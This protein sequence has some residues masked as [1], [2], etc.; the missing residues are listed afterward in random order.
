MPEQALPRR[1]ILAA[2]AI[3]IVA[4]GLRLWN[5]G[6]GIPYNVGQDEPHIMERVVRMMKTGDFNPHF[7]DW[8]SLTFYLNLVVSVVAFLFGAM[9]GAWSHLDQISADQLY[10]AGRQFTA[11]LGAATVAL[12][13]AAARRWSTAVG[14]FAAGFMAVMPNHVRESHYV[15]TDVPTTFFVTLSLLLALRAV[16]RA[17][18]RSIG[19]AGFAVGLAASCKYNGSIAIVLPLIAIAHLG[20]G[21]RVTGP[22]IGLVAVT[23]L[24]GFLVGTPY[25]ILDLPAFLNDYARLAMVFAR[26]RPGEAGWSVYLKHFSYGVAWPASI[27]VA[28]GLLVVLI[29]GV[30]RASARAGSFML[31]AFVA[32]YFIV[33][34][35]SAQIYGRYLLPLL[36]FLCI[37]C[38]VGV[39]S[40]VNW[41]R[42]RIG[43]PWA[44]RLATAGLVAGVLAIPAAR[45]VE[46]NRHMADRSTIDVAYQWIL[47]NVPAGSRLVIEYGVLRPPSRYTYV[48]MRQLIARTADEYRNDN[49]DYLVAAAPEY[50]AVLDN[51]GADP[52]LTGRYAALLSHTRQVASFD[53]S[54]E[55]SGPRIRVF[56]LVK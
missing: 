31:L 34:A 23:A 2:V 50:H 7:F 40:I 8:P 4:A 53:P 26:D 14:L 5:I 55:V 12:T 15:L 39:V 9:R 21:W 54:A 1:V 45:V 13:F 32:L 37:A 28:F 11:L 52:S 16:E 19:W 20:G 10:L 27:A 17:T 56:Q 43:N 25:A 47:R 33:M 18:L 51:P 48:G 36:P 6:A 46:L 41:M 24:A 44:L 49:V 35:R 38:G 3:V 30:R 42:S 29:Q 22:R